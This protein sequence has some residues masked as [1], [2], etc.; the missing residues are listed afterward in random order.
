VQDHS[1]QA[2]ETKSGQLSS[3]R[4]RE[5]HTEPAVKKNSSKQ[6][7]DPATLPL[8]RKLRPGLLINEVGR[9][10]DSGPKLERR[11]SVGENQEPI[12]T[13]GSL[14]NRDSGADQTG[15]PNQERTRKTGD[16][17]ARRSTS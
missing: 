1:A 17:G 13:E 6:M 2:G 9:E 15:A 14:G 7:T 16:F 4:C 11:K 12:A 10:T 3:A 8:W 5:M